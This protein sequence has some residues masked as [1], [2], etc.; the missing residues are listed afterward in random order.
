[1]DWFVSE[2]VIPRGA[3]QRYAFRLRW[4]DLSATWSRSS[5][6]RK[7]AIQI[8]VPSFAELS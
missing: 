3:R 2:L 7:I 5:P 8:R 6:F 1:M 4:S